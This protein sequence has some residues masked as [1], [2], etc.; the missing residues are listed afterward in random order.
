MVTVRQLL[1]LMHEN[2]EIDIIPDD[3]Q[4]VSEYFGDVL[5]CADVLPNATLDCAIANVFTGH[6]RLYIYREVRK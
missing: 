2:D 4:F 1:E 5:H 3:G 6:N